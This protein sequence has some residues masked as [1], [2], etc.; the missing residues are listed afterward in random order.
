MGMRITNALA[1]ADLHD[2]S[3]VGAFLHRIV[4]LGY[5]RLLSQHC[6]QE[7]PGAIR[8]PTEGGVDRLCPVMQEQ[9]CVGVGQSL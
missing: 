3:G 6:L 5:H 4:L 1:L 9:N 2:N 7:D 8:R